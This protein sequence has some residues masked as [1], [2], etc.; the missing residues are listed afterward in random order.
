MT[1]NN[2][3]SFSVRFKVQGSGQSTFCIGSCCKKEGIGKK[4]RW[5]HELYCLIQ[6]IMPTMIDLIELIIKIDVGFC[7]FVARIQYESQ[8][9]L[10]FSGLR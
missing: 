8:I 1:S 9:Q 3:V 2:F 6:I 10:L 7:N 4:V 5:F